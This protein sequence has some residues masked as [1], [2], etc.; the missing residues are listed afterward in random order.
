LCEKGNVFGVKKK[1]NHLF[2]G[3]LRIKDKMGKMEKMEKLL[4]DGLLSH[5]KKV[6]P[7][8]I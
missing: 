2:R 6:P 3:F 7:P 5:E 8:G 1:C 4:G